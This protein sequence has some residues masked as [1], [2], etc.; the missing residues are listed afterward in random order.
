M[1]SELYVVASNINKILLIV[2]TENIFWDGVKYFIKNAI[3][4]L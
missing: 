4:F 3:I 1:I 2:F